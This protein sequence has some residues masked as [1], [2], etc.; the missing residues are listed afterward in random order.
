MPGSSSQALVHMMQNKF[1]YMRLMQLEV[2]SPQDQELV[3]DIV[4]SCLSM[5][6]MVKSLDPEAAVTLQEL[7]RQGPLPEAATETLKQAAHVRAMGSG[8]PMQNA[9][10]KTKNYHMESWLTHNLTQILSGCTA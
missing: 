8:A 3:N 9:S 5:L 2:S 6:G 1:K 10:L 7:I 4:Q